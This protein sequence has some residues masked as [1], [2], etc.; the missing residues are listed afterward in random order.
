[1][2]ILTKSG[3]VAIAEALAA[4][5]LHVAWGSGDGS[6]TTPPSEDNEA[7]SLISEIGRRVATVIGFVEPDD[8]GSIILPTG[9]FEPS[10]TPTNCLYVRCEF[11]FADAPSSVIRE[12]AVFA[13]TEIQVGLPPGQDY[14]VPSELDTPGRLLHL[15][16]IAPI[17]RSPAIRETFEI[18]IIF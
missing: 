18:V 15:Q 5:P 14:F 9:T 3:R 17:F 1:M 13:G 12:V 4:R 16:N 6:W 7:T 10:V 2:S 8:G 11:A